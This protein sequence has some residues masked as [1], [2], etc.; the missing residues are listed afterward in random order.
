MP[1]SG[2]LFLMQ[3]AGQKSV[4]TELEI[5]REQRRDL[6]SLNRQLQKEANAEQRAG[7]PRAAESLGVNGARG[8][9]PVD[10]SKLQKEVEDQ[11]GTILTE[12][13]TARLK[14]ISLQM[15]GPKALLSPQIAQKLQLSDEQIKKLGRLTPWDSKKVNGV[16]TGE[17]QAVWQEM[18]GTPFRGQLM[19]P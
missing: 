9:V 14:Q 7:P 18:T 8:L 1:G 4:Q 19:Y 15:Q 6:D 12:S 11:L 5:S 16:L 10:N 3:L 13:Q 2:G 17:Q